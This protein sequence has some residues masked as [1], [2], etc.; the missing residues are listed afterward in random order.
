[1]P[2]LPPID[3]FINLNTPDDLERAEGLRNM[4]RGRRIA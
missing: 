3:W 2:G 1:L 4:L